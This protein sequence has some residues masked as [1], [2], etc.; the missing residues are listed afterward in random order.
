MTSL[1]QFLKL[2]LVLATIPDDGLVG[3]ATALARSSYYYIEVGSSS[4][5]EATGQTALVTPITT[6]GMTRTVATAVYE[7]TAKTTIQATI[8]PASSAFT[9]IRETA[10]LDAG[11]AGHMIIRHVWA[12]DRAVAIG[13]SMQITHKITV[14]R[15]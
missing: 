2:L 3:I 5:A 15:A 13:D 4:T 11:T 1:K 12:A 9:N 14:S 6:G 7:A 10:V 8:G